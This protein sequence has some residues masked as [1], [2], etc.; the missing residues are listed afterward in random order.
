[1]DPTRRQKVGEGELFRHREPNRVLSAI[2]LGVYLVVLY[3]IGV[4]AR[5][6]AHL[7]TTPEGESIDER[8]IE[9]RKR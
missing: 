7:S 9:A 5:R 8:A 1:V 6:R 3:W 2:A 4:R